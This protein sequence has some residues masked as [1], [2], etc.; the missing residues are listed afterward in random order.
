MNR[1]PAAAH[2]PLLAIVAAC[3]L[4]ACSAGEQD[5]AVVIDVYAAASLTDVFTSLAAEFEAT[6]P[7]MTVAL[8]FGG[9]SDLAAQIVEGAPAD[10]FAS[11]NQ[12]QMAVAEA[13]VA[14]EPADFAANVLTI[15]VP[16]GNPADVTDFASLARPDVVLVTCAPEVPCGAA[17][18]TL[19]EA[20]GVDLNPASE[21]PSV[22][23]VLG[24]VAAG[25]ADAGLV[26]VTDIARAEGVEAIDVD[27]AERAVT[28]YP[29][30]ALTGG[31]ARAAGEAFVAFILSE[32]GQ[33]TLQ[34]AGFRAP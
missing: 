27:G 20:L 23:D 1:T 15:V 13:F 30:A 22:T 9:S 12:R 26:Y 32:R 8:T 33:A 3:A 14:S 19:E 17:T 34:E 6:H 25:E 28:T 24:K 4:G 7:G 2:L 31:D 29:I 11:A 21:E 16:T 18:A 5:E 10:V